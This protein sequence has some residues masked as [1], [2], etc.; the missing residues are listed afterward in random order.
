MVRRSDDSSPPFDFWPY[1][2]SIEPEAYRG[3]D[4]SRGTVE[5]AY[6][7][8]QGTFEHVLLDSNDP[9]VFMVVVL[10]LTSNSVLGHYLLNL[11]V[12]YGLH[13]ELIKPSRVDS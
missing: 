1:V 8:A 3:F 6:R 5:Y 10:D 11:K 7:N 9:D 12:E 13:L 2:D 4:C